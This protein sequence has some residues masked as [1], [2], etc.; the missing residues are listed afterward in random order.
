MACHFWT[1][2]GEGTFELFYLR[3]KEKQEIDFLI[4]RDKRP[5]LYVESKLSDTKLDSRTVD[6]F[7]QQVKCP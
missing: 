6:E 4:V 2:A 1:D 5:W 3:N 7:L